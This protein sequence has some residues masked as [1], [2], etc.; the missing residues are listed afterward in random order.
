M[1]PSTA[2][3]LPAIS[4]IAVAFRVQQFAKHDTD[5]G[6]L[7][8]GCQGDCNLLEA[9]T[10]HCIPGPDPPLSSAMYNMHAAALHKKGACTHVSSAVGFPGNAWTCLF[11]ESKG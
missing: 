1:C 4:L 8:P 7:R 3:L 11:A 5:W 2:A 10:P 6:C 9:A